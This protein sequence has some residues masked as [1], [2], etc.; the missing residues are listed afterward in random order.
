MRLRIFLLYIMGKHRV[1]PACWMYPVPAFFN[2]QIKDH[3]ESDNVELDALGFDEL[4]PFL[5]NI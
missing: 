1:H 3:L 4:L 5:G 2:I